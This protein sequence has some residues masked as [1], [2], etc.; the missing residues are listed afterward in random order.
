MVFNVLR[1][2]NWLDILILLLIFRVLYISIKGGFAVEVFKLTGLLSAIYLSMHYYLT[3]AD[4]VRNALPLE[5]KMPL[6]FLDFLVFLIL[7]SIG[8]LFFLLLRSAFNNLIKIEAVSTLNKWGGLVLGSFRS[9]IL[10]SLLI[11]LL[12]IS[13]VPYLKSSTK[14]SYLGG[15]LV[16]ISVNIYTWGWFNIF[17]KFVSSEKLN[18]YVV[19]VRDWM[20][21]K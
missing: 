19:E 17:S 3:I 8:Y 4:F 15:R 14:A 12:A 20:V 6:E 2:F 10:S 13:S 1:Q 5:E 18:S 21:S 7:A 9:L 16:S 11:F